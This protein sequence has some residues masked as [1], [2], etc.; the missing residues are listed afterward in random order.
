MTQCW[1]KQK[2]LWHREVQDSMFRIKILEITF[3]LAKKFEMPSCCDVVASS[4]PA[5]QVKDQFL[6]LPLVLRDTLCVKVLHDLTL[7]NWLVF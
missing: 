2:T 6:M 1:L 7:S 4:L 3:N 5:S